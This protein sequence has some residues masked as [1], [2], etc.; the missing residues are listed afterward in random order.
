MAS[1][2]TT[3]IT[4][5][6][7]IC[8]W[9]LH[10]FLAITCRDLNDACNKSLCMLEGSS[11]KSWSQG[12]NNNMIVGRPSSSNFAES[13]NGLCS[14]SHFFK[15]PCTRSTSTANR[16]HASSSCSPFLVWYFNTFFKV[17]QNFN[18]GHQFS[19][20]VPAK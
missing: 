19:C 7:L 17:R 20:S 2:A 6:R 11:S 8:F 3:T 12:H 9:I 18:L 1:S 4:I 5:Y 16:R 15:S 13:G 10:I 14:L